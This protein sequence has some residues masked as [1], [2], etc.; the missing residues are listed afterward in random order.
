[1]SAAVGSAGSRGPATSVRL[2]SPGRPGTSTV[3]EGAAWASPSELH[4][5]SVPAAIATAATAIAPRFLIEPPTS[6]PTVSAAQLCTKDPSMS[7]SPDSHSG[8]CNNPQPI[9]TPDDQCPCSGA[10][11]TKESGWRKSSSDASD[12]PADAGPFWGPSP[13]SRW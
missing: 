7:R 13:E 12:A 2:G 3:F 11:S 4:P 1:T 9:H 10:I 8:L 5:D 6:R